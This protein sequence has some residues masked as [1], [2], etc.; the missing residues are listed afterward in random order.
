MVLWRGTEHGD[1]EAWG[2]RHTLTQGVPARQAAV[3]WLGMDIQGTVELLAI[4][5]IAPLQMAQ[6]VTEPH[7]QGCFWVSELVV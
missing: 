2:L 6:E 3:Q 1:A 7:T 4:S 5:L